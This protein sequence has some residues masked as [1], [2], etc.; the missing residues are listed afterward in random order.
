MGAVSTRSGVARPGAGN[1]GG[2]PMAATRRRGR[3]LVDRWLRYTGQRCRR[4]AF[5][6]VREAPPQRNKRA[7]LSMSRDAALHA[8]YC[9]H[10]EMRF[11]WRR[12]FRC[13]RGRPIRLDVHLGSGMPAPGAHAP[14]RPSRGHGRF[15]PRRGRQR[16]RRRHR[17]LSVA[18]AACRRFLQAAGDPVGSSIAHRRSP[19]IAARGW[20]WRSAGAVMARSCGYHGRLHE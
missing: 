15:L 18:R 17:M 3:G 20:R 1:G 13:R 10:D 16:R 8:A 11:Q 5:P 12:R 7:R 2:P 6:P 9:R 14:G 4:L 19:S